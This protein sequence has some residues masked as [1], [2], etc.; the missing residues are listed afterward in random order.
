MALPEIANRSTSLY[1]PSWSERQVM[2]FRS[3]EEE[4]AKRSREEALQAKNREQL[5]ITNS[6]LRVEAARTP[7]QKDADAQVLR[8]KYTEENPVLLCPRCGFVVETLGVSHKT[9]SFG[10]CLNEENARR[11]GMTQDSILSYAEAREA[12]LAT[13]PDLTNQI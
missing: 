13:H 5:E 4:D 12:Y 2:Q 10:R 9:K 1:T 6:R 11:S 8:D 3:V 7:E